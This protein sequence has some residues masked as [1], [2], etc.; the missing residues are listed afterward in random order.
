MIQ[1]RSAALALAAMASF[2]TLAA[3]PQPAAASGR[4]IAVGE[5]NPGRPG[6]HFDR[7]RRFDHVRSAR[8][9]GFGWGFRRRW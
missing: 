2:S 5:F 9:G 7:F 4:S 1:S 8:F 6:G 3:L